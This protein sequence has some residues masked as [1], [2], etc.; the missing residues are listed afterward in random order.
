[1]C[2]RIKRTHLAISV[3]MK[4]IPP[5]KWLCE[6]AWDYLYF[7][8][9]CLCEPFDETLF[10]AMQQ[11]LMRQ[12]S[13]KSVNHCSLLSSAFIPIQS[14]ELFSFF[15]KQAP[16]I[17]PASVSCGGHSSDASRLRA[18]GIIQ[19]LLGTFSNLHGILKMFH[20]KV[21][22]VRDAASKWPIIKNTISAWMLAEWLGQYI[23]YIL[24][25]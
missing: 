14:K 2:C 10:I 16:I 19:L 6:A 9:Y 5:L 7:P 3:E 1:M 15:F 4:M 11:N 17:F 25:H 13:R 12:S 8:Y 23:T 21:I 24:R 22:C 20:K 18:L